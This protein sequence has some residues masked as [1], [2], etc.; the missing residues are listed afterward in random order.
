MLCLPKSC[1]VP[2]PSLGD[3]SAVNSK[4]YG[5]KMAGHY[6]LEL[7]AG[8]EAVVKVRLYH[9]AEAPHGGAFS[10]EFDEMFEQRILEADLFYKQVRFD[11]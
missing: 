6:V 2:L 9:A 8:E 4:Q 7:G 3:V 10:K 1:L 11:D 5:T